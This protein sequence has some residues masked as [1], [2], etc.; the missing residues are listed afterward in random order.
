MEMEIG[1]CISDIDRCIDTNIKYFIVYILN[2]GVDIAWMEESPTASP[3][4]D[5]SRLFMLH[6]ASSGMLCQSSGCPH[7]S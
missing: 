5:I 3:P 7:T 1:R 6:C 4:P 2:I